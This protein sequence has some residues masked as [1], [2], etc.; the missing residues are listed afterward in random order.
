MA[1]SKLV[2][3]CQDGEATCAQAGN[4]WKIAGDDVDSLYNPAMRNLMLMLLA[5][6]ALVAGVLAF[7]TRFV[8]QDDDAEEEELT[9]EEKSALATKAYFILRNNCWSCHGE[10]GK[11]HYGETTP[12]DWI[13]DYDKLI[14]H[15]IIVP[16]EAG[17]SR[18]IRIILTDD[19]PRAL[20]EKGKPSKR[21]DL[22]EGELETLIE[23]IK[24]G[25]PKW[26]DV[27]RAYE[28]VPLTNTGPWG[29]KPPYHRLL[30]EG[31][32][33]T[34]LF[35]WKNRDESNIQ[36]ARLVNDRWENYPE[37][38]EGLS[39]FPIGATPIRGR[40]A[41]AAIFPEKED[42]RG[43]RHVREWDGSSWS[44]PSAVLDVMLSMGHF[45]HDGDRPVW[46]GG[47]K[48][49][50]SS[51]R[52]FLGDN[53]TAWALEDGAWTS[54][55]T[56]DKPPLVGWRSV[57]MP[58]RDTLLA[59]MEVKQPDGT[60]VNHEPRRHLARLR[61]GAW[62]PYWRPHQ[63]PVPSTAVWHRAVD[64]VMLFSSKGDH[65]WKYELESG[66]SLSAAVHSTFG[67]RDSSALAWDGVG[68]RVIL[69]G[70]QTG[71]EE[72]LISHNDTWALIPWRAPELEWGLED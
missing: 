53:E 42:N 58:D 18:L 31:H 33:G 13:L 9:E 28:W 54:F 57:V 36:V 43:G 52:V 45:I 64:W 30:V 60:G 27:E 72:S 49:L 40:Y 19:M 22:A 29:D 66:D 34:P 63:G 59:F 14:K 41:M 39:R 17:K 3:L 4:A 20:D 24:A 65:V 25:A 11:E 5:L 50:K 2:A 56:P 16:G 70:G 6:A 26:K 47:L 15:K 38:A 51:D 8:A 44:N 23:W 61:D 68:N 48:T 55:K 35:F 71:D 37:C 67:Q 62:S 46:V 7:E 1:T 32:D 69:Y 12:L 10:P 21:T